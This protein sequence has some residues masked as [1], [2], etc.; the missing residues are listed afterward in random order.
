MFAKLRETLSTSGD[1]T[2]SDEP[3]DGIKVESYDSTSY[4]VFLTMKGKSSALPPF[5]ACNLAGSLLAAADDADSRMTDEARTELC[6]V[7]NR[8]VSCRCS[9]HCPA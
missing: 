7:G 3:D 1:E 4:F 9:L 2:S 6:I 5:A 8:Q